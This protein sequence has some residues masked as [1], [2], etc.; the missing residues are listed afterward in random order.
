MLQVLVTVR[1][2]LPTSEVADCVAQVAQSGSINGPTPMTQVSQSHLLSN[3]FLIVSCFTANELLLASLVSMLAICS[4]ARTV[5]TAW[6]QEHKLLGEIRGRL[7][8][9]SLLLAFK[10]RVWQ[11]RTAATGRGV[12]AD[13]LGAA[14]AAGRRLPAPRHPALQGRPACAHRRPHAAGQRAGGRGGTLR[15]A[16]AAAPAKPRP[17]DL[18]PA[19]AGQVWSC[20]LA[21]AL[22]HVVV[23]EAVHGAVD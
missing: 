21:A 8:C 7:S 22:K 16:A 20:A 6:L 12:G 2:S 17:P 19:D 1:N 13:G 18:L 9:T 5:Q 11:A 15:A 14:A 4:C 3:T 10:S 23:H